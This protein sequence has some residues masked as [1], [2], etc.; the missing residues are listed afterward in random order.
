MLSLIGE[1]PNEGGNYIDA[2]FDN[3][4]GSLNVVS[5]DSS[6]TAVVTEVGNGTSASDLGIQGSGNILGLLSTLEEALLNNDVEAIQATLDLF[7]DALQRV[8]G[9]T[10]RTDSS[11]W[12]I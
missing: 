3:I 1:R 9:T 4:G 8:T 11:Y 2:G 7:D 5:T 10:W 6:T 12:W